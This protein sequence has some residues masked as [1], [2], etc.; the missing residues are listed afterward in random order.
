MQK[1]NQLKTALI[2]QTASIGDVILSTPVIEKI[3]K[4][5]PDCRI[6]FLLKKGNE[7]LFNQHPLL[8]RVYIWD[9]GNGKY[10]NLLKIL[11]EV[12][13]VNYDLVVNIQ[14]FSS[15]G[16]FTIFSNAKRTIGF[17]KNP[18]SLFFSKRIKHLIGNGMH[19]I[20]RN[21][22]LVEDFTCNCKPGVKLYPSQH[23]FAKMSQYK[24]K[25]YICIAPTSLWFTKQFPEPKWIE[26]VSLIPDDIYVYFLGSKS[27]AEFCDNII[28]GSGL[29]NALNLAGKL[30]LLETSALLKDAFMNYVN[31]SAPMHM[32]SAMNAKTVAIFCSTIPEFGFGPLSLD[33]TIIQIEEKLDCRP[34]GLHGYQKCPEEHFKCALNIQTAKLVEKLK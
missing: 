8:K 21:L 12:R 26:F 23:D 30:S 10:K 6:D 24:T 31:D 7:P 20:E 18:F 25:K 2:I 19:E 5:F 4:N 27:D 29:K 3:H 32:A 14:R 33:S 15:S 17:N 22:I 34:C 16:L 1:T 9:K 28:K 13:H 11:K